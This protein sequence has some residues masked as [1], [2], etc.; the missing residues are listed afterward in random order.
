M[1][2]SARKG[3]PASALPY[4]RGGSPHY[5]VSMHSD[6][7]AACQDN[8]GHPAVKVV[9]LAAWTAALA[10]AANQTAFAGG[11]S[12]DEE[13]EPLGLQLA[14]M[15]KDADPEC[16]APGEEDYDPIRA[17]TLLAG[18]QLVVFDEQDDVP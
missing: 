15:I 7:L 14:A 9:M 5:E 18:S 10:D 17:A 13:K 11:D 8:E 6:D 16:P 12:D 3:R 1:G 4:P 2:D